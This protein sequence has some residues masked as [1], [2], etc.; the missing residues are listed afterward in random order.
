MCGE[1][2]LQPT[3]AVSP[4]LRLVGGLLV[5]VF[6]HHSIGFLKGLASS[7]VR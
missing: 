7:L 1:T 5:S 4:E 6:G 2:T 3:L